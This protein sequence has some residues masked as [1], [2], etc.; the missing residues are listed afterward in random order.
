MAVILG[1]LKY[2][3]LKE[4]WPHEEYD[5]TPWLVREENLS[6]LSKEV[7]LELQFEQAEVPVGPYFADILAKDAS[8]RIVVIENQFG[9]TDHDHL[10]KVIAYS[11]TL[12][13]SVVIWIA[14]QF[15]E[16][17]QRA[18]EWLNERTTDDL[19]LFA[20]QPRAFQI[21]ASNPA[22]EFHVIERP[23]DFVKSV[24]MAIAA[25]ELSE[26]R[27]LQLEFWTAFKKRLL[28]KKILAS[29]QTPRPQY[30]FDVALGRSNIHLSNIANTADNKIGLRVYLGNAIADAAFAQLFLQKE[31]IEKEL[32]VSLQWNPNPEN[33]D[34]IIALSKDADLQSKDAW[35][36]YIE[37]LVDMTAKFRDVF[38]PRAKALQLGGSLDNAIAAL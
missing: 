26:A 35:P 10:G 30:W 16:Q 12:G 8:G 19:S 6:A 27:Q 32:G 29:A 14:E 11:A 38:M 33:R 36:E 34:K 37:W 3:K 15:T 5:F 21:D 25:G 28:E 7:G 31:E 4:V 17:H 13:A 22:I 1:A 2:L 23:N 18:I 24:A 9:K 20:V